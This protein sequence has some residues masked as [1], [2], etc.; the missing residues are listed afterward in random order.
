MQQ[1]LKLDEEKVKGEGD[2]F[3]PN[4]HIRMLVEGV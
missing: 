3:N 1:M 2:L 4:F